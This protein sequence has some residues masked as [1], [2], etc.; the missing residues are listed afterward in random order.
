MKSLFI[1]SVF[2]LFN[3]SI[4]AQQQI[5]NSNFE[6]WTNNEAMPWH[7]AFNLG[8]TLYTAE[9]SSDSYQGNSAAKLT[10]QSY[11]GQF[12]PG[13]ITLGEVDLINQTLTGGT[14]YT[15][16]PDGISFFFKYEPSGI[17]TMLFGAFLTKWNAVNLSTDTI[18][19]TGY[20]NSDTY[21][22]YT[23]IEL[24]FIYQSDEIPDTLNII[25][26][27]SGFNGNDGSNL[28]ID[29][30]SMLNGEVISPTL[31]FP[32]TDITSS[33]F[34]THWMTIPNAVS[35]SI[36]VSDNSDFSSFIS[37]Y[38]NLNTGTDTFTVVS[39]T[40]GTYYYRA[41]VNYSSATSI[42]SNTTEVVVE[43]SGITNLYYD[44]FK[45]YTAGNKIITDF[46]FE[47]INTLK[48]YSLDG[49]LINQIT[50]TEN[51]AEFQVDFSGIYIIQIS[52]NKQNISKKISV[53]F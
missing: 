27:S 20:L 14:P 21:N 36:D 1:I 17:D 35:Y 31:C 10:S 45:I 40:P 34:T 15:D 23:E 50:T 9:Q 5:P 11:F 6:T 48:L 4:I 41:R 26:T 43:A 16:R 38:E 2:I 18:G 25:F 28:Y 30:I 39:V 3:A 24:P 42:N 49:K 52:V 46:P 33:E 29:S 51:M 32:A 53:F 12:V 19:I 8:I 44:R 37:G 47:G 13:L 22:N 7:S